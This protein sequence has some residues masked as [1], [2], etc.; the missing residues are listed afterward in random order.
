VPG[1]PIPDILNPNIRPVR[2]DL[3]A[4][5]ANPDDENPIPVDEEYVDGEGDGAAVDENELMDGAEANYSVVMRSLEGNTSRYER[6]VGRRG[7]LVP[8]PRNQ[9]DDALAEYTALRGA[10]VDLDDLLAQ[11]LTDGAGARDRRFV[12]MRERL[13]LVMRQNDEAWDNFGPPMD[14]LLTQNGQGFGFKG[15]A[16]IDDFE[17]VAGGLSSSLLFEDKPTGLFVYELIGGN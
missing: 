2:P 12:R 5:P 8:I 9:L 3:G 1:A 17:R 15:G 4:P 14:N 7:G 6:A 11:I 16:L 10:A 13:Q